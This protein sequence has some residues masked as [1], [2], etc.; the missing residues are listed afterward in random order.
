MSDTLLIPSAILVPDEL[1][2]ELGP[3]PT[4]LIPL[5]G[6]PT[7]EHI[8]RSHQR[9]SDADLER[10]VAC[11]EQK[12]KIVKWTERSDYSWEVIDVGETRRLGDTINQALAAIEGMGM[13]EE[14]DMT[15]QFADTL[16]YPPQTQGA[17]DSVTYETVDHPIRWTT[18]ERGADGKIKSVSEKFSD[19]AKEQLST[20]VGEFYF[21]EPRQFQMSLERALNGTDDD[22]KSPFYHA[23]LTYLD[24]REYTLRR[25]DK[26]IDVGHLDTY[27]RAKQE[28]INSRE[29]NDM[30]VD[31]KVNT[32]RKESDDFD[33]LL[34]EINWYTE[35]PKE[36]RPHI[37]QVFDYDTSDPAFLELEYVGYPTLSD[38]YIYGDH[39]AHIWKGIFDSLFGMLKAFGEHTAA[40]TAAI[41]DAQRVMYHDKTTRRLNELKATR[42][43]GPFFTDV[44]VTVNGKKYVSVSEILTNLESDLREM[45]LLK[46]VDPT[47]IHGDLCFAN[48]LYDVRTSLIKLVD[49][50]GA[51]GV[52]D[53][54]GDY[55]Y[56]L[57]KLLHSVDGK[58]EFIINDRFDVDVDVSGPRVDYT[59]FTE[60][61][62]SQRQKLFYSMLE[63]KYPVETER[64]R[65]LES[66]LWLSMVPLHSDSPD[67]QY[68]MLAQ[69]IEKYSRA[70]GYRS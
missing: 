5:E 12:E 62:H 48:I 23:L 1:K 43:F 10:V 44:P 33:I 45:G 60:D 13:L 56:D 66:L 63:S 29:F 68:M 42:D 22:D 16:V 21:T 61:E 30:E 50:R 37:P 14:G 53:I 20:F 40:N 51:F 11:H 38:L 65:A 32:I 28:F 67:R 59:V 54:Y 27:Y 2:L 4:G 46:P 31:Q 39:G 18:F 57:A 58:Y 7:L 3:I 52:Y 49:P 19:L 35:L 6:R 69:G 26:W 41:A 55:R 47:I 8:A 15:I 17:V 9:A 64:V 25:P 24:G 70:F 36:L 34:P